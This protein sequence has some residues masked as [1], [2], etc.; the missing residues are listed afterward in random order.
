VGVTH[1]QQ[2]LMLAESYRCDAVRG[3]M[4]HVQSNLLASHYM[5]YSQWRTSLGC[6][7]LMGGKNDKMM[8]P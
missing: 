8:S 7:L 1:E 6:V 5:P 3:H 2:Y 4:T